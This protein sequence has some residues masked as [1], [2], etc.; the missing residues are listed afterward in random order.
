MPAFINLT[1]KRFG[2]LRVLLQS[3]TNQYGSLWLCKCECGN[4]ST[5]MR[6]NLTG[7]RTRSCGCG[8]G[9]NRGAHGKT[10]TKVYRTWQN[11]KNRCLNPNVRCYSRYGGVGVTVC[12]RWVGSFENFYED[13]GDPPTAKHSI[14]REDNNKGYS[15]DNCIWATYKQQSRNRGSCVM[16]S[17][18]GET[19]TIIRWS[20][21]LGLSYSTLVQRLRKHGWS[22]ERALTTPSKK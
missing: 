14:E 13:M 11:M 9:R 10:G 2:K 19:H 16:I 3:G 18:G 5:V 6:G 20:E 17:H 12:K 15:P 21:I 22:V 4:Y 8:M 1:G 7:G